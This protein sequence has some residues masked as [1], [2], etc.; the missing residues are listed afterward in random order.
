MTAL[1]S[2][3]TLL[4]P[5]IVGGASI[6][7]DAFLV[8]LV[9]VYA[10][11]AE[12]GQVALIAVCLGLAPLIAGPL[13]GRW[14]DRH[15]LAP[16]LW[17]GLV[18]RL[19]ATAGLALAGSVEV[20]LGWV[21]MKGLGNSLYFS[22][23][24][25][26]SNRLVDA[27]SRLR[28]Y[29]NFSIADQTCKL[30]VPSLAGLMMLWWPAQTLFW[31]S[32]AL[33]LATVPP[34][35]A[36]QGWLSKSGH[37]LPSSTLVPPAS[38]PT[39]SPALLSTCCI[40]VVLSLTLAIYDPHLASYIHAI[41]QPPLLFSA[42]VTA[43]AAG[44]LLGAMWTR[45]LGRQQPPARLRCHGAGAFAMS[46]AL[47]ASVIQ[48]WQLNYASA[49]ALWL[50]NG[51]GYELMIISSAVLLQNQAPPGRIATITTTLRSLQL[52]AMMVAPSVGA[53]LIQH[54]GRVAPVIAATLCAVPLAVLATRHRHH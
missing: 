11:N 48:G 5:Q 20:F 45:T 51:F 18:I 52:L 32:V 49:I 54:V 37:N 19:A 35:Y 13:V 23:F 4:L 21:V 31:I 3:W 42:L 40:G 9:P 14:V 24:A 44:A 22:T 27:T 39:L 47:A 8:F 53:L 12:P 6:W 10:W 38:N 34:V 17:L 36:I 16:T 30:A 41:G 7:L 2:P 29:S 43:T 46:I 28:Y 25:V 33:L 15:A 26:V 50:L 1:G